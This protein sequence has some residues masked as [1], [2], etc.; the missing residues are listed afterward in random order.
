MEIHSNRPQEK[1]EE[2]VGKVLPAPS[3]WN[4]DLEDGN[5]LLFGL[6]SISSCYTELIL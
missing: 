1:A 4:E 5:I 2:K 6:P 3:L